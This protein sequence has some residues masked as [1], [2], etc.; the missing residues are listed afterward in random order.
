MNT[1]QGFRFGFSVLKRVMIKNTTYKANPASALV[2][3]KMLDHCR[4]QANQR[5]LK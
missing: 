5:V 4:I 3:G 1:A 2:E